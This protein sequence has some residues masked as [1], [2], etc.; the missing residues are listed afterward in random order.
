[1]RT[2][3]IQGTASLVSGAAR[4]KLEKLNAG[5][6]RREEQN[7]LGVYDNLPQPVWKIEVVM[8]ALKERLAALPA[9]GHRFDYIFV[10]RSTSMLIIDRS[11]S[12]TNVSLSEP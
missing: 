12:I 11:A 2:L 1:M 5:G 9:D 6:F 7:W 3:T 8:A 4:D 10:E